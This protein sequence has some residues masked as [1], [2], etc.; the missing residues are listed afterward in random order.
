M[1]VVMLL[2]CL[3]HS[4][5][6]QQAHFGLYRSLYLKTQLKTNKKLQFDFFFF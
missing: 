2:W 6:V 1:N 5:L 4:Y 3:M